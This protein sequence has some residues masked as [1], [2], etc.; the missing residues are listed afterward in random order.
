MPAELDAVVDAARAAWIIPGTRTKNGRDH[1]IP[2]SALARDVVL[3]LLGLIAPQSNIYFR[4]QASDDAARE[5]TSLSRAMRYL[6]SRLQGDDDAI[7]TWRAEPP[8]PHDLRR[9]VGTRLA[10]LRVPK[11]VRDRCL[12]HAVGDVGSRHYNFHD[13]IDEK[14]EAL[15]RWARMV[16]AITA[17]GRS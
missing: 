13:Y 9:T 10:E 11:E 7:R 4:P 14:R 3:D 5:S 8:S 2:L 6:G 17:G 1:L 15:T 12:N 16:K